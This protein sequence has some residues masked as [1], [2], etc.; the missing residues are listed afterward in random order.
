LGVRLEW[1]GSAKP[2]VSETGRNA[3]VAVKLDVIEGCGDAMPARHSSGLCAAHM[4]HRSNDNVSE[5]QGLLTS[6]ISSS[7]EVQPP[8]AWAEE[9]D[10]RGA[11]VASDQCNRKCLGHSAVLRRRSGRFSVAR[12]T[13]DVWMHAHGVRWHADETPRKRGTKN[14]ASRR[15]ERAVHPRVVAVP[16]Q[17]RELPRVVWGTIQM[18]LPASSRSSSPRDDASLSLATAQQTELP[19]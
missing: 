4:R 12:G 9:I 18:E 7:I 5:A 11:H 14:G 10:A 2:T 1:N 13:P 3:I 6:T 8:G 16:T 17:V 19:N 15:Q